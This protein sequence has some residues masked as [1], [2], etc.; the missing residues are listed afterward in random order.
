[1]YWK[2]SLIDCYNMS[3]PLSTHISWRNGSL[4]CPRIL[5]NSPY[6]NGGEKLH[7][8]IYHFIFEPSVKCEKFLLSNIGKPLQFSKI[9]VC[10]EYG[11]REV[12]D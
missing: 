11:K 10:P 7:L 8:Q 3:F 6:I 9:I 5:V 12:P 1:M 2:T 4:S